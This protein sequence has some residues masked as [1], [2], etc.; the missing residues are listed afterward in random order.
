MSCPHCHAPDLEF[1]LAADEHIYL[2]FW[3]CSGCGRR[4]IARMIDRHPPPNRLARGRSN[5][6][7]A[8][9]AREARWEQRRG[10]SR[11]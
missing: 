11:A 8:T 1:D 6:C 7:S 5:V 9:P 4:G 10:L 3:V 2:S